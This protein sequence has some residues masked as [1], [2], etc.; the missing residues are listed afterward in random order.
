MLRPAGGGVKRAHP[1]GFDFAPR[2]PYQYR[3]FGPPGRPLAEPLAPQEILKHTMPPRKTSP[4]DLPAQLDALDDKIQDL[5]IKRAQLAGAVTPAQQSQVLRRLA[6][7]HKGNLPLTALVGIWREMMAAAASPTR[8][9]HVYAADRAGVFRDLAR[10]LFGS[11]AA[12][13]SHLSATAIMNECSNDPGAF[14]VVP[15]PESDEN[16]RAWW[17]QLAPAGQPGPRIVAT[18]PLVGDGKTEAYVVGTLDPEPT[19]DDTSLIRLEAEESVSLSRLQSLLKQ[20]G[21]E[22]RLLAVSRDSS[23]A[24]QHLLEVPGFV[25]GSDARIGVLLENAGGAVLRIACVGGYANPLVAEA[26]RP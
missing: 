24:R 8:I 14:G 1:P 2:D 15:P 11:V 13:Q 25:T 16:A 3:P 20:A 18:L 7:R 10:G 9:V 6:A 4:A 12:M 17:A 26:P 22:S 23:G 21:L 5:L 19:G